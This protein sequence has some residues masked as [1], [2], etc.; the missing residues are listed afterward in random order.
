MMAGEDGYS[1]EELS[2]D[3]Q[4][5]EAGKA[6]FREIVARA[7]ARQRNRLGAIPKLRLDDE[8][9]TFIL[10]LERDGIDYLDGH[11]RRYTPEKAKD[12]VDMFL[13]DDEDCEIEERQA[14]VMRELS[15]KG[16]AEADNYRVVDDDVYRAEINEWTRI[17]WERIQAASARRRLARMR[18]AVKDDEEEDYYSEE[19]D[20]EQDYCSEEDYRELGEE[21]EQILEQD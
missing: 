2:E 16:Y 21:K 9:V 14:R 18:V 20:D 1:T 11:G 3:E 5:Q 17:R 12:M 7:R 6:S 4:E 19:D 15:E 10:S 13:K 8:D